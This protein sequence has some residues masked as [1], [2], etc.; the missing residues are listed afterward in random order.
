MVALTAETLVVLKALMMDVQMVEKTADLM[1]SLRAEP[2]DRR[3][4]AS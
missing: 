2:W 4:A 1:V 3:S